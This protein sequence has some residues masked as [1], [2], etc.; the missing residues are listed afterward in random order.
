MLL[1]EQ[2]ASVLEDWGEKKF[3]LKQIREFLYGTNPAVD[4]DGMHTLP[5]SLRAK[6]LE[7]CEDHRQPGAACT[8]ARAAAHVA[9][10]QRRDARARRERGGGGRQLEQRVG[11]RAAEQSA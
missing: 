7:H 5:K 11:S 3:R 8:P 9:D 4:I 1:V 6:L 2:L 10:E